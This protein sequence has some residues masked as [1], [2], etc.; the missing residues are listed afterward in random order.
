MTLDATVAGTT[1]NAYLTLEEAD[2]YAAEDLG[3]DVTTWEAS[4]DADREAAIIQATVDIDEYNRRVTETPYSSTQALRYPRSVDV[5]D[6]EAVV[7]TRL[8]RATYEQAKYRLVNADLFADARARRARGLAA[9]SDDDGSGTMSLHPEMERW[10]DRARVF[11]D[12]LIRTG[13]RPAAMYAVRMSSG[14]GEIV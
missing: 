7:V 12:G 4:D 6:D 14:M 10:S 9:F 13:R 8:K 2:A 3:S 5:V 1:A 11:L